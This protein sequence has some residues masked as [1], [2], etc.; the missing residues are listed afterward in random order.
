VSAGGIVNAASYAAGQP[1]TPGGIISV[2]GRN[3]AQGLNAATQLPLEKSLGGA[4]L[5]IGGIEAPL[6]FS[7]EGQINGQVPFELAPNTR[8]HVVV[9]TT[10]QDGSQVFTLPETITVGAARPAIFTINQ[11]GSGQGAILNQDFSPNS[12]TNAAERGSVVQIFA[13]GLG[14]TNPVVPSGQAAPGNPPALVIAGVE[15]RIGGQPAAVQFAGLAPGFVGLYQVNV[16][17]PPNAQPGSAVELSLFQNGVPS[18]TVTVAV[19]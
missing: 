8:P 19:R 3:L 10:R 7:S 5:S 14:A 2:F 12:A 1:V 6:F 13:T 15:A 17:V 9:R 18:N 11:A 16:V 4:T